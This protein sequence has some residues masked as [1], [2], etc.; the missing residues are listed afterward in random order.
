MKDHFLISG[1]IL[2]TIALIFTGCSRTPIVMTS[3]SPTKTPSLAQ[4]PGLQPNSGLPTASFAQKSSTPIVIASPSP[5]ETP[6][7]TQTPGLQ[8]NSGLPTASS[9][10][11]SS[12]TFEALL[13]LI[14]D[15]PET[16]NFVAINDYAKMRTLF[17]ISVPGINATPEQ[18]Y[19]YL[20]NL[21]MADRH[22]WNP[23][24]G[25]AFFGES[26]WGLDAQSLM[27]MNNIGL[28]MADVDQEVDVGCPPRNSRI[29]K[30]TFNPQNTRNC[31]AVIAKNDPPSIEMYGNNQVFSWGEDYKTNLRKADTAPVYDSLGRGGRFVFQDSYSFM[32]KGTDEIK[33][34]ID[35]QNG[36]HRSLAEAKEF[37]LLAQELYMQGTLTAV[38]S[39]RTQ[40]LAS[41]PS[42]VREKVQSQVTR[43]LPYQALGA[44]E[45]K[46]EKGAYILV[47]LVHA[48][49]Q[50]AARNIA[51]LQRRINETTSSF[52]GNPWTYYFS[53]NTITSKEN[54]LIGKLYMRISSNMVRHFVPYGNGPMN[55]IEP[56]LLS[57]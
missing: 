9:V 51:L 44:G 1:I 27:K 25:M 24:A 6:S 7:L 36:K 16:R 17:Q 41:L 45:A 12:T 37:I 42:E 54:V 32:T 2:I 55:I 23:L 34:L 3:P 11:K 22:M 43:L 18:Q 10:K 47:I 4:T 31:L 30:G 35:T 52:S 39:N 50:T 38:L 29:I 49:D 56:L 48:D 5:T 20:L 53:S 33:L 21:F 40:A 19:N 14:P 15:T 8:P 13:S 28:N 26:Y 46:D 57:D